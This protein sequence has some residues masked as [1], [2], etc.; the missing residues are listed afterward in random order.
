MTPGI[1]QKG[2]HFDIQWWENGDYKFHYR[3]KGLEFRFGRE[4]ANAEIDQPV[5][6]FHPPDDLSEHRQS[7][8]SDGHPPEWVTLAVLTSWRA[9]VKERDEA[10]L[11]TQDG[12]P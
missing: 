6:H 7:C 2:G 1:H 5:C 11:N 4:A 10:V 12:L 9:A 3:E 8:I